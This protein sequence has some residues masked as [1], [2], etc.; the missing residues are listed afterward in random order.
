MWGDD[1]AGLNLRP[2]RYSGVLLTTG[3]RAGKLVARIHAQP[4]APRLNDNPFSN[5][6]K[7]RTP[8]FS[9]PMLLSTEIPFKDDDPSQKNAASSTLCPATNSSK[10]RQLCTNGRLQDASLQ[11]V[12]NLPS[13]VT[14][15][16]A[17]RACFPRARKDA[18]GAQRVQRAGLRLTNSSNR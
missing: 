3:E 2:Q 17:S 6:P 1:D 13:P 5:S 10:W 16:T 9:T 18:D 7:T 12:S 11:M 15:R 14:S 4:P 8:D